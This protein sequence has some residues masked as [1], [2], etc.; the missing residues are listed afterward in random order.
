MTDQYHLLRLS[1][2]RRGPNADGINVVT[3]VQARDRRLSRP[4]FA[5]VAMR[6]LDLDAVPGL[7]YDSE[8]AESVRGAERERGR[9]VG[10]GDQERR[11]KGGVER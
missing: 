2:F 7:G 11:D 5:K 6:A 3:A 10:Q 9:E 8:H 1:S 4:R